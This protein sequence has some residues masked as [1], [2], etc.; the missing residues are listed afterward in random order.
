MLN[1][2]EIQLL[3]EAATLE[4]RAD[5]AGLLTSSRVSGGVNVVSLTSD[6]TTSL[7]V[8][9]TSLFLK[10]GIDQNDRTNAI[11]LVLEEVIDRLRPDVDQAVG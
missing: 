3:I 5:L 1:D 6:Q 10:V 7:R 8:A 11:G 9:C 4:G 2:Q